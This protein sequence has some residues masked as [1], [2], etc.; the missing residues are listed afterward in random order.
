MSKFFSKTFSKIFKA[1]NY[2]RQTDFF[3]KKTAANINCMQKLFS[4]GYGVKNT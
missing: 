2:S 4:R 1:S 3:A